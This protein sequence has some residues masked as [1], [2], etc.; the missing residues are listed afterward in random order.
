MR[1]TM[2]LVA[3][4][5]TGLAGAAQGQGQQSRGMDDVLTSALLA[6]WAGQADVCAEW[7]DAF[8][9]ALFIGLMRMDMERVA[10]PDRVAYGQ[11][12]FDMALKVGREEAQGRRNAIC[13]QL[14]NDGTYAFMEKHL[15][16]LLKRE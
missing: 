5:A 15:Q 1:R 16:R 4:L 3:T 12:A 13:A 9:R 2:I 7:K 6:R 11:G 10:G 8:G 14:R